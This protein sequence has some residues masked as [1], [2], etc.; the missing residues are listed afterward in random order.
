MA[1]KQDK[2]LYGLYAVVVHGGSLHGGHYTAYVRRRPPVHEQTQTPK[3]NSWK[4]DENAA[5]Q[6]KWHYTSDSHVSSRCNFESVATSQA[7]LLFYERLPV[8]N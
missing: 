6:G 4:Y 5:L 1:D 7:Y 2:I 8:I 3:G